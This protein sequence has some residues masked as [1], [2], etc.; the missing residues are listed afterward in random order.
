MTDDLEA[1][2]ARNREQ[3]LEWIK[4]WAEIVATA[5]DDRVWGELLNEL[6]DT[7]IETA[8]AMDNE[9]LKEALTWDRRTPRP[10]DET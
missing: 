7:Q 9:P 5:E 2:H 3:R 6:I 1:K 8:Q 4:Q 10:G